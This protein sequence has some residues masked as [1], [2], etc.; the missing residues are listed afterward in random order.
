MHP[1]ATSLEREQESRNPVLER[2]L[3]SGDVG[4]VTW[5]SLSYIYNIIGPFVKGPKWRRNLPWLYQYFFLQVFTIPV[6]FTDVL[7]ASLLVTGVVIT[8]AELVHLHILA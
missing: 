6:L 1:R 8:R 5:L 2:Q 7:I 3:C 4:F